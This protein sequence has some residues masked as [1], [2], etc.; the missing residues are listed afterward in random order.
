MRCGRRGNRFDGRRR[1]RPPK[2]DRDEFLKMGLQNEKFVPI[3]V[4]GRDER[5]SGRRGAALH[6]GPQRAQQLRIVFLVVGLE[7]AERL[8]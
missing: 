8:G 2:F 3:A 4:L 7:A 1:P 5:A 6:G